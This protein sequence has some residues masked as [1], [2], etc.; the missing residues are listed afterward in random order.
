MSEI[1]KPF[2]SD[3]RVREEVDMSATEAKKDLL[4][5]LFCVSTDETVANMS[6]IKL[7]LNSALGPGTYMEPY[8]FL[9]GGTIFVEHSLPSYVRDGNCVFC[10]AYY[11]EMDEIAGILEGSGIA[12]EVAEWQ[13]IKEAMVAW[14]D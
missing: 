14:K 4:P 2:S 9:G 8:E 13:K 6:A 10:W 3:F 5:K 7:L 12:F 1:T 11:Q